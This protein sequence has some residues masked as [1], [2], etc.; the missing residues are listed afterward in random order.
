MKPI[1]IISEAKLAELRNDPDVEVL[2]H[3]ETGDVIA[4]RCPN[5][6]QWKRFKLTVGSDNA[7]KSDAA[8]EQLVMDCAVYPTAGELVSLFE[9]RPGLPDR[10]AMMISRLAGG[11]GK[12]EKKD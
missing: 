8:A 11:M 1:S 2:E 4:V 3:Q 10:F 6:S 5:K 12:V 9:R 7:E